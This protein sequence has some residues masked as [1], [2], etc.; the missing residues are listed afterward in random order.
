MELFTGYIREPFFM[1]LIRWE[2]S[3]TAITFVG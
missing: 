1:K 3:I 2:S